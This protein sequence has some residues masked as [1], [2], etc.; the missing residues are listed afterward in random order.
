MDLDVE[1]RKFPLS[2]FVVKVYGSCRKSLRD[3]NK[4]HDTLL[5]QWLTVYDHQLVWVSILV[6]ASIIQIRIS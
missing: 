6:S 5:D 3:L 2:V 1:N 4:A